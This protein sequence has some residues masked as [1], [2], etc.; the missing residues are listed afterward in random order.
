[1]AGERA[2]RGRAGAEDGQLLVLLVG[3]V[4]LVMLV[5]AL[6]WDTSNWFI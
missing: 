5:L 4:M 1:L 6:G 3:L 2:A